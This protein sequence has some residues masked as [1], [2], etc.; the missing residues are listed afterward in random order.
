M[1]M[2]FCQIAVFSIRSRLSS[3]MER[4]L[5]SN[6]SPLMTPRNVTPPPLRPLKWK[7]STEEDKE[8]EKTPELSGLGMQD[9]AKNALQ[10]EVLSDA[11]VVMTGRE[12]EEAG[13]VA[14]LQQHVELSGGLGLVDQAKLVGDLSLKGQLG[15]EQIGG[16]DSP[17]HGHE[18]YLGLWIS[19]LGGFLVLYYITITMDLGFSI[20]WGIE[21]CLDPFRFC[22]VLLIS[23]PSFLMS[24]IVSSGTVLKAYL[25]PS[26]CEWYC[27]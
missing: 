10:E 14:K 27:L 15:T 6:G 5:G 17:G 26:V 23:I 21:S 20:A 18:R 22:A 19:S 16:G 11:V 1:L 9:H 25:A 3:E 24:V 8:Q 13:E 4:E 7:S 12:E 2:G